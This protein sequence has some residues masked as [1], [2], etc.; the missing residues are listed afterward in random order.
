MLWSGEC[1]SGTISMFT[2]EMLEQVVLRG[3][4]G[5]GECDSTPG[6]F[7]VVMPSGSSLYL[8]STC[9]HGENIAEGEVQER[10]QNSLISYLSCIK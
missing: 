8:P 7:I 3:Q 1:S 2:K 5:A 9:K 4:G 6:A 10:S